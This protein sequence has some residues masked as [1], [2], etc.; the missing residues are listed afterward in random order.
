MWLLEKFKSRK[1]K[2]EVLNIPTETAI[3]L[4]EMG[5]WSGLS[6]SEC[7]CGIIENYCEENDIDMK[8]IISDAQN[9][10]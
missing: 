8:K 1:N 3:L 2:T 7:A 9:K 10:K 5:S 6:R 4:A